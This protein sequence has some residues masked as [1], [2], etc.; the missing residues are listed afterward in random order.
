MNPEIR[1]GML[2]CCRK[3]GK[4]T[5][6]ALKAAHFAAHRPKT[7]VLVVAPSSRQSEELLGIAGRML[8]DLK[9]QAT[10]SQAR[11][12]LPNGSRILALPN[13]PETIRGYSPELLVVDEAA[14]L[15]E[16]IWDAVFPMLNA[17]EHGGWLWLMSTPAQPV[18]FFHRLWTQEGEHWERLK[19]TAYD[20]PR[21]PAAMI[22]EA[23]RS[24]SPER[25]GREYLC[26]FQ[27][28]ATATFTEELVRQ[29]LDDSLPDFLT[30]PVPPAMEAAPK[31][32]RP[33]HECSADLG[34]EQNPSAFAVLE[35]MVEPTHTIDPATRAP[36]FRCSLALRHLESPPLGTP[37]LEVIERLKALVRHPRLQGRCKLTVDAAGVGSPV[38]ELLQRDAEAPVTGMVL[39]SGLQ[40]KEEKGRL[41]VPKPALLDRLDYVLRTKKL[42]IAPGPLREQLVRELTML[43]K[44]RSESGYVSYATKIDD[45]LVMAVAMGVWQ[46]WEVQKKYL[47]V[48]GPV[49]IVGENVEL[50]SDATAWSAIQE[51]LRLQRGWVRE[52]FPWWRG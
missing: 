26:E 33:G 31:G 52:R 51:R 22:Q 30:S 43:Q 21:I 23:K 40:P 50:R 2:N 14:Y 28:P 15:P 39:T 6:I 45:D 10:Y 9:E 13:Q 11:I 35:F 24:F 42:R 25:F 18:G 48:E 8:R 46:A 5:M 37:Y 41:M 3:W 19:V 16:E 36:L 20:C 44:E 17:A 1:R 7:T 12:T 47:D 4:S 34:L 32:A 38:L 27:Q 29:C 49:A